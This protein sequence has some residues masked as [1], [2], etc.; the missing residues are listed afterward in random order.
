MRQEEDIEIS[1]NDLRENGVDILLCNND[2]V[3][4]CIDF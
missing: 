3:G 1:I 4:I 2:S